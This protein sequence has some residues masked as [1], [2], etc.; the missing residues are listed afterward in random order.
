MIHPTALVSSSAI[1]DDGVEIGAY[2]IIHEN[3]WI[4]K[5]T[6][7]GAFCEIGLPTPLAKEAI[8]EIGENSIIRSHSVIYLGSRIGSGL[9]T[10]HHVCIRENSEISEG[11]QLGSRTDVQGDCSIGAYTKMHAD[12]HIGKKSKIGSFVWLFPEVLLTNDP[13]PPSEQLIGVTIEDYCV[14]AAKVLIFPGVTLANNAVVAAGSVVKV[15]IPEWKLASGN[16]AKPICDVRIL[17]MPSNPKEKAYPWRSRFHRG[18][19]QEVIQAWMDQAQAME[20]NK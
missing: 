7:V 14:V 2:S 12:V 1:I 5:H 11:V 17:R 20:S 4:K 10:G 6:K 8:L 15:D 9:Q 3:V 19:P 18:Y 13:I 16:P